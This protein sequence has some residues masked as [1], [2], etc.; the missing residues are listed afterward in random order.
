MGYE[1]GPKGQ[2]VIDKRIR[3][4]LGVTPGAVT[5]QR[6]ADGRLEIRFFPPEHERSLRGA[7]ATH[8]RRSVSVGA[9]RSAEERAW[10]AATKAKTGKR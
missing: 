5:S 9:W 2:V 8:R 7:L 10:R 4:A 1:V 3:D 6:L